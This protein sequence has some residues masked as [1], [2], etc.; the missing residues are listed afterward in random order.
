M[1]IFRYT[2]MCGCI[3]KK[4]KAVNFTNVDEIGV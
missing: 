3:S 2:G 1:L 4:T